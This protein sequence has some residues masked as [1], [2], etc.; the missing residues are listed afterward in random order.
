M[1][2]FKGDLSKSM[3]NL[4]A[5]LVLM[6]ALPLCA[7]TDAGPRTS[8]AADADWKFLLADP[9]VLNQLH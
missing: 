2:S 5:A 1:T 7:K 9:A 8:F 6:S 4:V 3:P